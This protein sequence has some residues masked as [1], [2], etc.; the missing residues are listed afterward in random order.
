M[1]LGQIHLAQADDDHDEAKR[2]L[3]SGDILSLE[4]ILERLQPTYPGKILEVELERENGRIIYEIELLA[5]DGVVYKIEVDA[6]TG[7][8][9][10]RKVD[11]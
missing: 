5:E 4:A 1:L 6:K 7:E 2:L 8:V 3:Q 11:D 10:R 9:L